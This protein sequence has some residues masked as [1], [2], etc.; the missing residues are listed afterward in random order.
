[1]QAR[2]SI[3][4]ADVLCECDGAPDSRLP[5]TADAL[6]R[7]QDW[8][9]QYKYAVKSKDTPALPPLG[10]DI[11]KWL[12]ESGWASKWV[13]GVGDRVLEI[14]VEETESDAARALLDLPWEVLAY[15]GDFL[16]AD[17]P[18]LSS[19]SE[20]FAEPG[21]PNPPNRPTATWP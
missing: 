7:L 6:A 19:S 2:L 9:R 14:A 1:M 21:T 18:N 16:A 12:D 3:L 20:V 15:K 8:A 13:K 4:G 17:P 10:A 5:I 11:F